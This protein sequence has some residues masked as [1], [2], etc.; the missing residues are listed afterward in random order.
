MDEVEV[1]GWETEPEP[2]RSAVVN[3]PWKQQAFDSNH[4][5]EDIGF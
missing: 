1:V 3:K 5:L 2:T 4:P